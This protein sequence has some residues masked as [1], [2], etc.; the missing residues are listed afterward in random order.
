MLFLCFSNP[1]FS[2]KTNTRFLQD[3]K[4]QFLDSL[5]L[6]NY[7]FK[8]LLDN[9]VKISDFLGKTILIDLWYSGCGACI[10]CNE[11]LKPI[12]KLLLNKNVVFISISVDVDKKKWMQSITKKASKSELNPWAGKYFPAIGSITLYCGND[13]S[14][15]DF[16]KKYNPDNLYPTLLLIDAS[17]KLVTTKLPRPEIDSQKLIDMINM[18]AK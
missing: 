15:N 10:T 11:A 1:L 12:H 14:N 5:T 18:Y 3:G 7:T 9:D 13:G 4:P 17:G 8:D 2:Q 6:L 16:I